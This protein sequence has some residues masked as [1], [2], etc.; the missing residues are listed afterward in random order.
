MLAVEVIGRNVRKYSSS[1]QVNLCVTATNGLSPE[2]GRGSGK[3]MKVAG[4]V[5]GLA[6]WYG[7]LNMD[8]P[9]IC[10]GMHGV[11]NLE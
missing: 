7:S 10:D 2:I 11:S 5:R 6:T 1:A 3:W 9:C 4:A 8:G